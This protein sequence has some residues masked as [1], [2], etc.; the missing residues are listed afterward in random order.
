MKLEKVSQSEGASAKDKAKAQ[1]EQ[2]LAGTVKTQADALVSPALGTAT[3]G[4]AA[5]AGTMDRD[6]LQAQVQILADQLEEIAACRLEATCWG[7]GTPW[8]TCQGWADIANNAVGSE[9]Q[10]ETGRGRQ[11]C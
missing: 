1:T 7:A 8:L 4:T 11:A 10:R 6:K 5:G 9:A 2:A 3:A